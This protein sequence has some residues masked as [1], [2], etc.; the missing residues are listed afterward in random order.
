MLIVTLFTI[1]YLFLCFA[2]GFTSVFVCIILYSKYKLE[3]IKNYLYFLLTITFLVVI[4]TTNF[5]Y[6]S[7]FSLYSNLIYDFFFFNSLLL[8]ICLYI[9]T[10]PVFI[11]SLT[12]KYLIK[13]KI[14]LAISIIPVLLYIILSVLKLTVNIEI[15]TIKFSLYFAEVFLIIMIFHLFCYILYYLKEIKNPLRKRGLILI[16]L[17]ILLYSPFA[18]LDSFYDKFYNLI[19][20][21]LPDGFSFAAPYYFLWNIV[22]LLLT[23]RYFLKTSFNKDKAISKEIIKKYKIT[24]REKEIISFVMKGYSNQEI[25]D[26]AFISMTTVKKHIYNLFLKTGVKN[27]IELINILKSF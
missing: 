23:G 9:Y 26:K 24:N 25:S 11:Y 1:F 18:V 12:K 20:R 15:N 13:K 22:T 8:G 7:I 27:R 16:L 17:F 14:L 10:L 4:I 6:K 2:S 5:Y 3:E 19:F 21:H